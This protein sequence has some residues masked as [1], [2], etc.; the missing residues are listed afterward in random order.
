MKT[1]TQIFNES[2]GDKGSFFTHVGSSENIAH[3]YTG[4]YEKIMENHRTEEINLLEIGIWCPFFPG[5]SVKSWPTYFEKAN[6]YGI[7]IVDCR[8]LS[9][10]RVNIDIV[11]QRSES[12][13]SN[14]LIGKPKF[15]F[16]IDDGCHEEDAITISLG[17][18]FPQVESGGFYII[19]DLHVVDKTNLRKLIHKEFTSKFISNDKLDYINQNIESCYFEKNEKMLIIKKK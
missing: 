16:I 14:Y 19:E 12:S 6:Y 3:F 4:V 5:A 7:D 2:G 8:H 1:L 11:D 13:I 10:E 17:A 9:R 18:F 15:K